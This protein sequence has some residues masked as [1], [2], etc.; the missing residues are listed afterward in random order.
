MT[1]TKIQHGALRR[2]PAQARTFDAFTAT[3]DEWALYQEAEGGG[4]VNGL[5]ERVAIGCQVAGGMADDD[6]PE[7]QVLAG[8]LYDYAATFGLRPQDC[9]PHVAFN[10]P[11]CAGS[12]RIVNVVT[13]ACGKCGRGTRFTLALRIMSDPG[14]ME[15]FLTV[16]P[17]KS[18]AL[19]GVAS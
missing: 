19:R 6:S 4:G 14:L 10:C 7:A 11:H 8:T 9:D 12:A 1:A 16:A 17:T 18:K 3:D 5:L 15:R 13:W 2:V